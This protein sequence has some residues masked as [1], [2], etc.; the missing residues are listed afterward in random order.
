MSTPSYPPSDAFPPSDDTAPPRRRRLYRPHV[1][2]TLLTLGNLFCGFLAIAKAADAMA[3]PVSSGPEAMVDLLAYAGW[4]IF[5][6]MVFDALD[7]S[8]A[9]LSGGTSPLGAQL[10]SL[11]DVVTFGV[12]PAMVAKSIAEGVGGMQDRHMTLYFSVFFALMA[13]LRLARYN[14]QHGDPEEASL[15]FQGLPTP[16]A[17]GV[18]AGLAIVLPNQ[19]LR[20]EGALLRLLPWATLAL[21]LLMVS[22]LPF[23]HFTNRFLKGRK[24]IQYLVG[25]VALLV[26]ALTFNLPAVVASL[27]L[28]YALSGPVV[29]IFRRR[30]HRR[31]APARHRVLADGDE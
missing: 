13:A 8:V 4:L 12:A 25:A 14:V 9:R 26:L 10:D 16:G 3:L 17:A 11:A 7:G 29:G 23:V 6:G 28:L 30:R 2:P 21:G 20:P 22:R 1:L 15:W 19:T 27:L 31:P 5:L 18:I 24:P